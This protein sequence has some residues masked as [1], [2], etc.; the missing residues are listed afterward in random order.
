MYKT[1]LNFSSQFS[2]LY[3]LSLKNGIIIHDSFLPLTLTFIHT[4]REQ[5][6]SLIKEA[7]PSQP[8]YP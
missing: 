7:R 1:T 8:S 5:K 6:V 4:I 2:S 3:Q